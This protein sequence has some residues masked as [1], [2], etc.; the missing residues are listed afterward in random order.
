MARAFAVLAFAAILLAQVRDLKLEPPTPVKLPGDQGARW[1]V[2]V[3][4]ST[5]DNLP[6]A[7]QLRFAHRDAEEFAEFLRSTSGGGLPGSHV[8]VLTNDRATLAT[9]RAAL[10]TWLVNSA[11]PQDVA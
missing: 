8:R 7:A 4:V 1:A 9:I 5:Y 6:P 10:H 2:V 3:G 11:G